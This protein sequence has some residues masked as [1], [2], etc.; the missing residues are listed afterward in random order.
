M[1]AERPVDVPAFPVGQAAQSARLSWSEAE[2][3]MYMLYFPLGQFEQVVLATLSTL[4]R[5]A[6]RV[7]KEEV[8]IALENVLKPELAAA[9]LRTE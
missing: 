1:Q 8:F 4:L 9:T 2:L 7:A 6:K 5:R 3:A